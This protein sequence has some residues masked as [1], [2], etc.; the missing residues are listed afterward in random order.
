MG[1]IQNS[2]RLKMNLQLIRNATLRIDYGGRRFVIDPYL[3]AKGSRPSFTGKSPNPLVELPCEPQ[4]VIA[5][6]ELALISHLH[7]DHFD[8]AA[9]ELLPKDT[10]ILCQPGDDA[11]ISAKGFRQVRTVAESITWGGITITRT[12]CQHGSGDVL[13]DM[14]QAS[15]FVLQAAHEPTV[16][17]AG[18][19]I[20]YEGVAGVITR[21]QPQIIVIHSCGAVWGPQVLIVMDAAQ[22]VAVCRAA[23]GSIVVATHMDA[24]DHATVSRRALRQYATAQ[25]IRPEQLMIPADGETLVF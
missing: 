15:G 4:D 12:A 20:W 5:N 9:Q 2:G 7:S 23:P 1:G 17:W 21:L 14:G 3:A 25:G 8:P 18:D 22:T 10:P 19:T 13:A 11:Q 24:L 6:I 16:Y